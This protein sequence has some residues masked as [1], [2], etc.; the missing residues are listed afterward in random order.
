M[1]AAAWSR[2]SDAGPETPPARPATYGVMRASVVR[3]PVRPSTVYRPRRS[4]PRCRRSRSW[5][6]RASKGLCFVATTP[7]REEIGNEVPNPGRVQQVSTSWSPPMPRPVTERDHNLH[8][9]RAGDRSAAA[10]QAV[11]GGWPSV[12]VYTVANDLTMRDM[13]RREAV[14]APG[15]RRVLPAGSL[16]GTESDPGARLR[17]AVNGEGR[18]RSHDEML[19]ASPRP[20]WSVRP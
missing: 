8:S 5:R 14:D 12:F 2:P 19:L 17:G 1:V 10:L 3:W 7:A 18:Q 15:L 16:G 6:R 4:A 11:Q 9:G 13:Q 20:A